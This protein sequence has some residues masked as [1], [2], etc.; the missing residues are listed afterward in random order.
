MAVDP[1]ASPRTLPRELSKEPCGP[2]RDSMEDADASRTRKRQR[3]DGSVRASRSMSADTSSAASELRQ[4]A[5]VNSAPAS[6][7]PVHSTPSTPP[8]NPQEAPDISPSPKG[9]SYL[10]SSPLKHTPS[11]VTINV[12]PQRPESP[13]VSPVA[14][15]ADPESAVPSGQSTEESLATPTPVVD[16]DSDQVGDSPSSSDGR[17]PEVEVAEV[18]DMDQEYE[19][20]WAPMV[21][22]QGE[23]HKSL[24][25]EF[26]YYNP[27]LETKLIMRQI[28]TSLEKE[29]DVGLLLRELR[30]W[31][32][33]CL[34][35]TE[36]ESANWYDI[37]HEHPE[38]WEDF[39]CL[40]EGLLKRRISFGGQ[41]LSGYGS[42]SQ[43]DDRKVLEDLTVHF[44]LLS[45]HFVLADVNTL[46]RTKDLDEEP[47][48]ISSPY[49]YAMSSCL[50]GS[51]QNDITFWQVLRRGHG[52]HVEEMAASIVTAFVGA[53]AQGLRGVFD[54]T[55][56]LYDRIPQHH[57][58]FA[59]GP[60]SFWIALRLVTSVRHSKPESAP[61]GTNAEALWDQIPREAAAFCRNIHAQLEKSVEQQGP[62]PR[63]YIKDTYAFIFHV[64]LEICK[65]D[66]GLAEDLFTERGGH[67][68]S[69][70]SEDL[71][72]LTAQAWK[73]AMLKK[74]IT[75]GRMEVRAQAVDFFGEDLVE[76][77]QK[78]GPRGIH[79]PVMQYLASFILDNKLVEYL[80]SVDSHLQLIERS[81]NIV[82]FLVVTET[83]TSHESDVIWQM[84]RTS[85]DPRVVAAI[86]GMLKGVFNMSNYGLLIYLC[87]KLNE[88]P[89]RY[90]D[91]SMMEYSA[92][93]FSQTK[94]KSRSSPQNKL[95]TP[96]YDLCIRLIRQATA[97]E[98]YPRNG[99]LTVA[100]FALHEFEDLLLWGPDPVE[101]RRIFHESLKDVADK[102]PEAT[103]SIHIINAMLRQNYPTEVGFNE[104]KMLTSDFDLT[105]LIVGE[106]SHLTRSKGGRNMILS[107]PKIILQ[108]RLELISEIIT[109]E[110]LT[111]T[112]DLGDQLWTCVVGEEAAGFDMRELGWAMLCA[113]IARTLS[114]N[115]FLERC[116]HDKLPDLQ[117]VFFSAGLLTFT[118][119]GIE[120]ESRLSPSRP[121]CEHQM[122][123][124]PGTEQVWRIIL[125]APPGTI[126][127]RAIQLLVTL[128]TDSH[129]IQKAPRSASEATHLALVDRC[130]G[131]LTS[132]ASKL[133][134]F[135]DG[136]N[137]GEDEPMV[138]IA[139]QSEIQAE[140]LS[141]SRSLLFLREILRGLRARR[142]YSPQTRKTS[143]PP[144]PLPRIDDQRGDAIR[145]KYQAFSIS[146][147]A[148]PAIKEFEVGDLET[149]A[150]FKQHIMMVTGFPEF[151]TICSGSSLDLEENPQM[152]LRDLNLGSS[153]FM[154]FKKILDQTD[155]DDGSD[156]EGLT[157]IEIELL[158]HFDELYELL[159]LEE[160]LAREIW[161]FLN[162]FPP[163]ERLRK[164]VSSCTSSS[165]DIFPAG[166]PFKI[167]YSATTLQA[168]LERQL[169][170]VG[171]EYTP[172]QKIDATDLSQGI[173]NEIFIS[174][175]VKILVSAIVNEELLEGVSNELLTIK[176]LNSLVG[177]LLRF[178]K[179]PVEFEVSSNYFDEEAALLDRLFA[180]VRLTRPASTW[181]LE[182]ATALACNAFST[183]LEASLHSSKLWE[184]FI[185][186]E[187]VSG[188]IQQ[189]V[190]DDVRSNLRARIADVITSFCKG[191]PRYVSGS[192]ESSTTIAHISLPSPAKVTTD[193]FA[194]F[195]WSILSSI[196]PKT[197]TKPANST[198]LFEASL[199]VFRSI[200]ES[201]KEKLDLDEYIRN[202]GGILRDHQHEEI[203]GHETVDHL[204]YGFTKLLHWCLQ[205]AKSLKRKVETGDLSEHLFSHYLFPDL[206]TLDGDES[207][208]E[209]VP[210]LHT[211]TRQAINELVLCLLQN[212]EHVK[213]ILEI[214]DDVSSDGVTDTVPW[215]FQRSKSIRSATGYVGLHNLTN[216]C[217][218]NSLLTQL[219]MN[220][221]FRGFM[222]GSHVADARG[223]QRLLSETQKLFAYMQDSSQVS[224]EPE[225][226]VAAI[227]PY[228][229]ESID[230]TIQMDVEEFYN[231]LFDRWEG[232]ILSHDAKKIFRSF[233]GG[234]LVQQVKSKECTHISEREEPFSAI[235]CD[236]KGKA[237]LEESLKAYV[238]GDIMEG[239]NKY[240]CT[241]CNR[242]VDAV[243]RTCLKDV[244]DNLIFH[245]K[246]F[247]FDLRTMQR[248]KINDHFEFPMT[249]DMRPYT[250]DYLGSAEAS[251]PDDPFELVGV[252][253]HS[254]T[255]DSGHYYSFIRERPITNLSQSPGWVHFNDSEVKAWD[256][257]NIPVQCFGG[258]ETW[259][260]SRE[261]QPIRLPRSNNAYMLFYQR[262]SSLKA[263]QQAQSCLPITSPKKLDVPLQLRNHVIL[264]NE[265][266]IRKYCLYD[267]SHAPFVRSLL[268]C[269]RNL[270]KGFCSDSHEVERLALT[271][272][273]HHLDH[274]IARTK[275][276]PDLEMMMHSLHR[277][278]GS[279][280]RCCSFVLRS[281]AGSDEILRNLLLRSPI[282]KVRQ[283][284]SRMI[285]I[286]MQHLKNKATVE[287]GIEN[288]DCDPT[289]L[290]QDGAFQ[291]MVR[292]MASPW[293]TVD[294]FVRAW[295]EY[296]GLVG[297]MASL[298]SSE[299]V[300]VLRSGFLR[301]CL[302]ILVA[303]YIPEFR[304]V[305]EKMIRQIGKKKTSYTKLMELL[306]IL[307]SHI[308]LTSADNVRDENQRFNDY[309]L[310]S[311][312]VTKMEEQL[313]HLHVPRSKKIAFL[314]KMLDTSHNMMATRSI[315]GQIIRAE[316]HFGLYLNIH[317]MLMSCV[318][319]EP[320]SLAGPYLQAALP[321]CQNAPTPNEVRDLITS[322]AC[323]VDTIGSHGGQ[324]HLNFFRDM[325]LLR[326]ER[327][328]NGS[329][330]FR[331]KTLELIGNFAPPL[332]LYWESSVR[333]GTEAFI[334]SLVFRSGTPS[335]A[336]HPRHSEAAERA[337]RDLGNACLSKLNERYIV[338][339]TQIE[340]KTLDS[341]YKVIEKCCF[342]FDEDD[343]SGATFFTNRDIV[344]NNLKELLVEETDQI[345][346]DEWDNESN[347]GSDSSDIDPLA[348]IPI[349]QSDC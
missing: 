161:D 282:P 126:E 339:N 244:P 181:A 205:L 61:D 21:S 101:R 210:I 150:D 226:L 2:R 224:V 245:L 216:T 94:D 277:V 25:E 325:C 289:Q 147:N 238:E 32:V 268:E 107:S 120:Y 192:P 105:S 63:D 56:L 332:L 124:I 312:P 102:T 182:D 42:T 163:Q 285:I 99:M 22:L 333:E 145:I 220:V 12:R 164:V 318:T 89:L 241:S 286:G 305:Y 202:W 234:Q 331:L 276:V 54:F 156:S 184:I 204:V 266:Y 338:T 23:E 165:A 225:D 115:A 144:K 106:I 50:L 109:N 191:L 194:S 287:Y 72:E 349:D 294:T 252:L 158:K 336:N 20:A 79:H 7:A 293:D 93:L 74:C 308:D 4:V 127:T 316:P 271:V 95:D 11:R 251:I 302:E 18:E 31:I 58:L 314:V 47:D 36:K 88:L 183:I 249:L 301:K 217:Y 258:A 323:E 198:Q 242:H 117:P 92:V 148:Q 180:V 223:S 128:Y 303:E 262:S 250:I 324:E 267:P 136:T 187:D 186:K 256:P 257:G 247:D 246:R 155:A 122:I 193:D 208:V 296:F 153:P 77:W 326:N 71:P 118:Q 110:P 213:K 272:A 190:L 284:L 176:V 255:A 6:P 218:L 236:I 281:L 230:V 142:Q 146:R 66:Q 80:V 133:K 166:F 15:V 130:V 197:T 45:R 90:F 327:W 35:R 173:A 112:T 111:I 132:A 67:L 5:A 283:E 34:Q 264:E 313:L 232:Q 229:A 335:N 103:G 235:Q 174:H 154:M 38:F 60:G 159:A 207:L 206:S 290:K 84:V 8:S 328:Q 168:C 44:A 310:G 76:T 270:N 129:V 261:T 139:S 347:I 33:M 212:V 297:Q 1:I 240:S 121:A 307:L 171:A 215:N 274:I 259:T 9:S 170:K 306:R 337:A 140:E 57:R 254:G 211:P 134:A 279:C 311:Y 30:D 137:S 68:E 219:F 222:M 199:A 291:K 85:P 3:L 341:I 135:G 278:I 125:K 329:L 55:R 119:R 114:T 19:G 221:S 98:G 138:I 83:Y 141:F 100:Q 160:K 346:P 172:I 343:E 269:L 51:S 334:Q 345:S 65:T 295:D 275:D 304:A 188:L 263:E 46:Q 97:S 64:L 86:L 231:L 298:G 62:L 209:K 26:P 201:L 73:L 177:C 203:V 14:G 167:M 344:L 260:Q 123:E 70:R 157:I 143:E 16:L 248:I 43:D 299:T 322:L 273:L 292:A 131:Q 13:D 317:K 300:V 330:Y 169:K 179:E 196:L 116:I 40:L 320:A 24:V 340:P 29:P 162:A 243:K 288:D 48:V 91:S 69:S 178:L 233:F 151:K 321:F 237:T 185:S 280:T 75:S 96:P 78:Y 175:S 49:Q 200:G 39:P 52:L 53:Q 319:L 348:T 108:P 104:L 342:Y 37:F 265:L 41:F 239:D 149:C 309:R 27:A 113:V 214:I 59:Q 82:G 17:S 228:E 189:L 81:P 152:M 195:F 87:E 253:V 10:A 315:V 227:R 28:A